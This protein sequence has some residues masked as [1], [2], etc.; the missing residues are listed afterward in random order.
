MQLNDA[1]RNRYFKVIDEQ[2]HL[3]G[4]IGYVT[5]NGEKEVFIAVS[6]RLGIWGETY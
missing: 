3:F 5:W 1:P 4:T 2:S 6:G